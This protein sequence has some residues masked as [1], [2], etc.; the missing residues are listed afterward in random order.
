MWSLEADSNSRFIW[1]IIAVTRQADTLRCARLW[2]PRGK[3]LGK[4]SNPR[5]RKAN[6]VF[7]SF[8][9]HYYDWKGLSQLYTQF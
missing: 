1:T 8:R 2:V 9:D 4:K 5:S 7:G 3:D 6:S